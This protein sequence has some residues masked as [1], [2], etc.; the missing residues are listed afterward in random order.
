MFEFT[1]DD[2]VIFEADN[3]ELDEPKGSSLVFCSWLIEDELWE[4]MRGVDR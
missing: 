2:V 1:E 3:P 4:P